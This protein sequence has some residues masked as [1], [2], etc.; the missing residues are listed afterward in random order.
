MGKYFK[1]AIGEILLVVIGILIAL[2]IN[3][4]NESR[5]EKIKAKSYLENIKED[6]ILDTT[7]FNRAVRYVDSSIVKARKL[8][9]LKSFKAFDL[10]AI[11]DMIPQN[12]YEYSVNSQTF[13]KLINSGVTELSDYDEIFNLIN[14][15]YTKQKNYYQSVRDW[16]IKETIKDNELILTSSI[17]EIPT[18]NDDEFS[19]TFYFVQTEKERFKGLTKLLLSVKSRNR[20]RG[21]L[22]RKRRISFTYSQTSQEAAKIINAIDKKFND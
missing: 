2:Q 6:L 15:Y 19:D 21:A 10:E 16:D 5:K 18:I 4:W 13:D 22:Y 7:Q 20:L 12:Y 3:N 17:F 14:V 11:M 1:Y 9:S 8:L